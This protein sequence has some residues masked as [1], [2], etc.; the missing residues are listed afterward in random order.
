MATQSIV[1]EQNP[2]SG[3][4]VFRVIEPR[5]LRLEEMVV[6]FAD[7][8]IDPSGRAHRFR[9]ATRAMKRLM[10]YEV[11]ERRRYRQSCRLACDLSM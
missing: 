6:R 2:D 4:A 8:S 1:D 7:T 9:A 5:V 10:I 3:L 11:S